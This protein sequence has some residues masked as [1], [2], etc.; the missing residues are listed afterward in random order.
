MTIF[1]MVYI[2]YIIVYYNLEQCLFY[3][4]AQ[5]LLHTLKKNVGPVQT[6]LCRFQIAIE[7]GRLNTFIRAG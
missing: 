6:H 7:L 1:G 3:F 2:Y 4:Y 5:K